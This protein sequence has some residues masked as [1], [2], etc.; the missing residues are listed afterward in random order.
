M[1]GRHRLSAWRVNR[2]V[3]R[4][5]DTADGA[6][7]AYGLL[8]VITLAEGAA[9]MAGGAG[10][11]TAPSWRF[12]YTL[13]GPG[14]YGAAL[15]AVGVALLAAPQFSVALLR[16]GL[17][18]A[19][20]AHLSFAFAFAGAAVVDPHASWLAVVIFAGMGCHMLSHREA[21]RGE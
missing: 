4:Y 20:T 3:R 5:W 10:R 2:R 19:A 17:M 11:A 14:V 12:I 8:S 13:G 15:V 18:V 1:T 9:L 7:R 6:A 16:A 21:Y